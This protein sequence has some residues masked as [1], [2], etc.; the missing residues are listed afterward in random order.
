MIGCAQVV[1]DMIVESDE[2]EAVVGVA[3]VRSGTLRQ[4]GKAGKVFK[5]MV[6]GWPLMAYTRLM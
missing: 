2:S 1:I 5:R 4:V 6:G 3:V